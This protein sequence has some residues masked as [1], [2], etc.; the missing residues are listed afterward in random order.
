M[1]MR[2]FVVF[3][4]PDTQGTLMDSK[5]KSF[6]I[7]TRK[8]VDRVVGNK[9]WLI[10]RLD[11]DYFL[12]S[13]FIATSQSRYGRKSPTY[14]ATGTDGQ[15]LGSSFV[16]DRRSAWW[17]R[18]LAKTGRF[19][20]GLTEITDRTI[21]R[22]FEKMARDRTPDSKGKA[23]RRVGAG[24]GAPEV[25]REIEKRAI[26]RA[27]RYLRRRGWK[28]QSVEAE[29]RG[30]DLFCTKDGGE[31]HVEVKGCSGTSPGFIITSNEYETAKTDPCFRLLIVTAALSVGRV[32]KM[33]GK[34][35]LSLFD[36]S[37]L[38]Y[39]ARLKDAKT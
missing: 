8:P 16:L 38:S 23:P 18:L 33:T 1:G 30:Y 22:I 24:F 11:G 6:S 34:E 20:W 39:S 35:A 17:K 15:R 32:K 31:L 26:D 13:V 4:N 9:V 21:I 36:F 28:V 14:A 10:T 29:A 37:P 12:A 19:Q 27:T 3:H 5:G 7:W 2:H 25:N